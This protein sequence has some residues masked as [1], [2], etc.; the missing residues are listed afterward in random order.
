MLLSFFKSAQVVTD[1][2]EAN[3]KTNHME[4]PQTATRAL[5][6]ITHTPCKTNRSYVMVFYTSL[7]HKGEF[8]GVK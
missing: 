2:G 7:S 8:C 4:P 5:L 3:S 1:Y 6:A